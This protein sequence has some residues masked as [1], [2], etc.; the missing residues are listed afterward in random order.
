MAKERK[1]VDTGARLRRA[2]NGAGLLQRDIAKAV[3]KTVQAVNQWEA[4]IH[5]IPIDAAV[6]YSQLTGKSLDWLLAGK[7]PPQGPALRVAGEGADVPVIKMRDAQAFDRA[8]QISSVVHRATKPMGPRSFALVIED[9]SNEPE[10]TV[11]D[12]CVF[13]PDVR[14]EP[15]RFVLALVGKDRTPMIRRLE[16]REKG[17]VLV[18]ANKSWG[19][20]VIESKRDGEIVATMIEYTRSA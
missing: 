3:G 1:H 17:F 10:L 13:D 14:P 4:G 8:L 11:G 16:E 15:G 2:R 9:R 5:P 18:P 6:I 19:P 20:K 12:T 7:E